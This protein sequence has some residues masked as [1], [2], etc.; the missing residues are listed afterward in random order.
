MLTVLGDWCPAAPD[1]GRCYKSQ[2]RG[3]R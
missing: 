1:T 3:V 2:N